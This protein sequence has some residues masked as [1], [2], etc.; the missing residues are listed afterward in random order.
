MD[1]DCDGYDDKGGLTIGKKLLIA[2][3]VLII[4]FGVYYILTNYVFTDKPVKAIQNMMPGSEKNPIYFKEMRI[5][6]K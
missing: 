5:D 6:D 4:S 1:Y 2:I 3:V